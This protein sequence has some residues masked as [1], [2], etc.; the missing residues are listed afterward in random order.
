LVRFGIR[1]TFGAS[2]CENI[3]IEQTGSFIGRAVIVFC[4]ARHRPA[5]TIES[6]RP[7][8]PRRFYAATFFLPLPRRFHE[9]NF[10]PGWEQ[11]KALENDAFSRA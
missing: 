8:R 11:Q 4:G 1:A 5:I 7:C 3:E 2:A 10:E 6:S 9:R